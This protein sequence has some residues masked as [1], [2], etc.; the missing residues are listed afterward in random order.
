MPKY[1]LIASKGCGSAIV[2]MALELCGTEYELEMLPYLKPGA[3][4]D[5]LLALNVTGQVP[6]LILPNGEVMSESAAMI[7]HLAEQHPASGLAPAPDSRTRPAFLRWLVFLV[8]QIYP[9]FNYGDDPKKWTSEGAAADALR[10]STD[11]HRMELWHAVEG[12]AAA[13]PW[14]LGRTMSAIDLYITVMSHWRPGKLTFDAH[15][16]KLA[17]IARACGELPAIAKVLGRNF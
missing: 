6:T 10:N 13:T 3:G 11:R 14:F 4:R 12:V 8:A 16:P 15:F 9:T 1:R 17:S 5:R 2:E 7:L